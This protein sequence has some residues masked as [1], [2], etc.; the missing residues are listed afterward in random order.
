MLSYGLAGGQEVV[1][2]KTC[3]CDGSQVQALPI[4]LAAVTVRV[5]PTLG[6]GLAPTPWK[7]GV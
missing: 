6:V 7:L 4:T 5:V 2:S 1:E 3:F